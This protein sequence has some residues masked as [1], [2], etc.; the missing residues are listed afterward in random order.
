MRTL[1]GHE[2]TVHTLAVTP[3]GQTLLSGSTDKTVRVWQLGTG[4]LCYT[5][6]G[7]TAMIWRVR[8]TPSGTYGVSSSDDGTVIVWRVQDGRVVAEYSADRQLSYFEVTPDERTIVVA[9]EIGCVHFL[10]LE[11]FHARG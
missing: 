8:V 6:R 2:S 10:R 9:D 3:D 1:R 5:L 11:G 7:H 4:E